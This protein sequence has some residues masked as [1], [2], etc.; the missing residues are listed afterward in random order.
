MTRAL[1]NVSG[2]EA[3]VVR[4]LRTLCEALQP[5]EGTPEGDAIYR[6]EAFVA[7]ALRVMQKSNPS[8]VRDCAMVVEIKARMDGRPELRA[9][10]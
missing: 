2:I 6:L 1:T 9:V 10:G 8:K 3:D 4:D 7:V 5:Q